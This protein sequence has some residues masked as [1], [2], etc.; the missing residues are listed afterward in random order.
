MR[1]Y[2]L[3]LP[4]LLSGFAQPAPS[5]TQICPGVPIQVRT[6]DFSPGGII[7]TAFD[8]SGM[9]VYN[10]DRNSRYPLPETRPCNR[11]C[12]LSP[13]KR[14]MTYVD[15]ATGSYGKMRLDGTQ[16]TIL[17]DYASDIEW[18]PDSRLLIWTP[19]HQA[20]WRE[21]QGTSQNL[22]D[23]TGVTSVQPSGPWGLNI[24][25]AGD[26]F[27]RVL[28]NLETRNLSGI[29]GDRLSLGEDIPYFNASSWSPN[30]EQFA[31]IAPG[32][33]DDNTGI[34]GG[35]I[36]VIRPD[37]GQPQQLTDLTSIYGAARVNGGVRADLSW[38]PDSTYLAFWVIELLGPNYETDTGNAVIHILDTRSGDIRAYCGFATNEHTPDPPR[39]QWSPDGTHLAFGGNVPADDKGYLLLALDTN[40]GT[41]TELSNGIYPAAGSADVMAWG[42][43]PG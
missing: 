21:E 43:P 22:I 9:W 35:E 11:Q 15:P 1:W 27:T 7:L 13:D 10:I 20:Y 16:R 8:K 5:V 12:R 23:V 18:W 17:A 19:G 14:W 34:A 38:S 41:F 30:G 31:Y 42:L 40:T 33:H 29:A 3:L 26:V 28:L 39:L 24:E 37:E 6:P 36:F 4:L 2:V 25:Q 32:A